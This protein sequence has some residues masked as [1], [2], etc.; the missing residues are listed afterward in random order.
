M[1]QR[2]IVGA[3]KT[4][5]ITRL[6]AR[7]AAR[8]VKIARAKRQSARKGTLTSK[9]ATSVSAS[10]RE[11]YLGHFGTVSSTAKWQNGSDTDTRP[12]TKTSAK[13]SRPK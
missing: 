4:G 1:D 8:A 6:Q 12:T 5:S 11:R 7:Q 3:S 10:I 9:A 13:K 2:P